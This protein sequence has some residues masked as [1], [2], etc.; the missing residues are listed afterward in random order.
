[1]LDVYNLYCFYQLAVIFHRY[2]IRSVKRSLEHCMQTPTRISS[3]DG[4][5]QLA[6]NSARSYQVAAEYT[7][8]PAG[9]APQPGPEEYVAHTGPSPS[10]LPPIYP[11]ALRVHF[12]PAWA[13][14][15]ALGAAG[16]L[17]AVARHG[18]AAVG[19][20]ALLAAAALGHMTIGEPGRPRLERVEV[21]LPA[22]PA[23]LDGLRIGQIS[24]MHLGV[25]HSV[26]N[27]RWALAHMRHER[28]DVIVLTGDQVMHRRAIPLL[29]PLLS[30]LRAPLGVYAI[31]GNHDYWEGLHDVRA[32]LQV[33]GIPLLIN[34]HRRLEWRG[35][36]LW[37]IGVDD[38][39]DGRLDFAAALR[40]VPA[41][42]F[43]LL[44]GHEPDMADEAA[45][46][47]IGLQL[48]GHVHGGHLRLPFLGPI[49]RPR[50]G[51]RYLEGLYQVG[52]MTLYVSRGLSGAPMR[53]LCRP[54]AAI[55]TLRR[56]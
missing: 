11:D 27:A 50:F 45:G 42:G 35:G 4:A 19:A 33:A 40:D 7:L 25:P 38:I 43:K 26:A 20:G 18:R 10:R 15:G 21:R 2:T 31:P 36:T 16:S 24:D 39:W 32:A 6:E 3:G 23:A 28:P 47:G 9:A 34:E 13:V 53:L 8:P 46:H 37:L 12:N 29:T 22:L 56:G 48:A 14:A 41:D 54:E 5:A 52:G 49:A 55:I 1:M 51:L 44:L 30:G 17:L